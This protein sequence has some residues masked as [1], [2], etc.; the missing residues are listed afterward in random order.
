QIRRRARQTGVRGRATVGDDDQRKGVDR[1]R[2]GGCVSRSISGIRRR[3]GKTLV[4]VQRDFPMTAAGEQRVGQS[5]L[6]IWTKQDGGQPKRLIDVNKSAD[7]ILV[8]R[9]PGVRSG[10]EL[11]C[12][13]DNRADSAGQ[14]HLCI[15]LPLYGHSA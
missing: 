10:N 11:T 6:L 3:T 1:G 4:E 12:V 15:T 2:V 13:G 14:A 8:P 9:Q 7:L 5:S